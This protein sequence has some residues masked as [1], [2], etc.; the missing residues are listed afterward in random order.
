M[1][2]P[3]TLGQL[4]EGVKE[5]DLKKLTFEQGLELLGELVSGVESGSL[6]LDRAI[7]SYERGVQLVNH[8]RALLS[9]AEE[10][11]RLLKQPPE[12]PGS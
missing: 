10:K 7:L 11:L 12:Q 9:G 3:I 6:P 2:E 8:L 1:A 5:K 4:L